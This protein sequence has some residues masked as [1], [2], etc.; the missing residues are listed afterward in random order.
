MA[1]DLR[2]VR[3]MADALPFGSFETRELPDFTTVNLAAG[4]DMTGTARLS[5]RVTNLFDKDY[6]ESWGYA[7]PG[8]AAWL[9]IE[10]R[11]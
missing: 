7:A 1:A 4:Y 6:Q 9:G 3:D 11:W 10:T 8:R 5:A 2:H